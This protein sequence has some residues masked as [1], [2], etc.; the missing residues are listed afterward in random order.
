MRGRCDFGRVSELKSELK[1]EFALHAYATL[2][3]PKFIKLSV[4][5]TFFEPK[6]VRFAVDAIFDKSKLFILRV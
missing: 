6:L 4:D 1:S 5:A 2:V 3:Q